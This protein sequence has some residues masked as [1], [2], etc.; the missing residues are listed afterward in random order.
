M[1]IDEDTHAPRLIEGRQYLLF[2]G[3]SK[4]IGEMVFTTFDV[5][6]VTGPAVAASEFLRATPYARELVG[7]SPPQALRRIRMMLAVPRR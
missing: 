6:D 4:S 2:L 7:L 1:T 3:F 5:F